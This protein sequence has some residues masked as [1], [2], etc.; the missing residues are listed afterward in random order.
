MPPMDADRDFLTAVYVSDRQQAAATIGTISNV[1]VALITYL[2]ATAVFIGSGDRK[3]ANF[4]LLA[5]PLPAMGLLY[6]HLILFTIMAARTRSILIIEKTL[7]A[8][9]ELASQ[10]DKLGQRGEERLTNVRAQPFLLW[11]VGLLAYVIDAGLI[12]SYTA[13]CLWLVVD[14][15]GWSSLIVGVT[16]GY[17]LL[18][19]CAVGSMLYLSRVLRESGKLA[20]N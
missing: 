15:A 9:T 19:L 2:G 14:D 18:A 1:A 7:L 13:Y 11:P 16:S 3:L 8:R 4:L 6:F 20:K 12:I 10:S 5:L 17:S